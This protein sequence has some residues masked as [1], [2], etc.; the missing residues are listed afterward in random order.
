MLPTQAR[1]AI[2]KLDHSMEQQ[3]WLRTDRVLSEILRY[4]PPTAREWQPKES[5]TDGTL[6]EGVEVQRMKERDS[7]QGYKRKKNENQKDAIRA[8]TGTVRGAKRKS[9][10]NW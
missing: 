1:K 9:G 8:K 6:S 10:C 3:L 7:E 4:V 2:D 5:T